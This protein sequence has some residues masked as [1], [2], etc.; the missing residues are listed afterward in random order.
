MARLRMQDCSHE[1]D[2]SESCSFLLKGLM[3]RRALQLGS[4]QS[5]LTVLTGSGP[6]P[7]LTQVAGS[8]QPSIIPSQ[9]LG[10]PGVH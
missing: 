3:L 9:N 7:A 8:H 1:T 2:C 5:A 10:F 4:A 6:G